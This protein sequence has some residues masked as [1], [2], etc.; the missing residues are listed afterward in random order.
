MFPL[1]VSVCTHLEYLTLC[2]W[3][4]PPHLQWHSFHYTFP[5]VFKPRWFCFHFHVNW[6]KQH[7]QNCDCKPAVIPEAARWW[8]RGD[9]EPNTGPECMVVLNLF[10]PTME[11]FPSQSCWRSKS[12]LS[13]SQSESARVRRPHHCSLMSLGSLSHSAAFFHGKVDLCIWLYPATFLC[14]FSQA[15]YV[16]ISFDVPSK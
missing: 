11:T 14:F 13:P 8:L 12:S 4:F 6:L 9:G 7:C 3:D 5:P 1:P 2:H 15:M 16:F 10:F